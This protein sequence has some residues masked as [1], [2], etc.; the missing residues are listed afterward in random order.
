MDSIRIATCGNQ[1]SVWALPD[2]SKIYE[3]PSSREKVT[4]ATWNNDGTCLATCG[5]AKPDVISLTFVKNNAFSTSEISGPF[6]ESSSIKAVQFPHTS[7]KCLCLAVSDQ[8]VLYDL[9]KKKSRLAIQNTPNVTCISMSPNDKYI[10]AGNE[11]GSLF[12]LNTMMAKPAFQH[13]LR[14]MSEDSES[15]LTSTKF[16]N[17]KQSMVGACADNGLL[18]FWDINTAKELQKFSE[19]KAPATGMAFSPVNEALV[20]TAG[21][22]KRCVC[23]DTGTRK[24][25]STIWTDI[26]LTSVEF[27]PDGTNLALGTS[28]GLVYLY[29]LR[30]FN[31]PTAVFKAQDS[32]V[33]SVLF[34][35][36]G[37]RANISA[38]LAS[39]SKNSSTLS[40][41]S[42]S[43]PPIRNRLN[44]KE[45]LRPDDLN[46]TSFG[47]QVFSPLRDANL[48]GLG[49]FSSSPNILATTPNQLHI[50]TSS[51]LSSESVLSP[52]RDTSLNM[53]SPG[54]SFNAFKKFSTPTVLTSIT[55]ETASNERSV[56][57]E[58]SLSST[59][60]NQKPQTPV[61]IDIETPT[62]AKSL[63][64][65][66]VISASTPFY[67]P[68]E[69]RI[70]RNTD[71]KTLPEE[72]TSEVSTNVSTDEVRN[73]LTAF[74]QALESASKSLKSETVPKPKKLSSSSEFDQFRQEFVQAAVEEAMDEFCA[75]MRKQMWHWHYDMIKAFQQQSRE[76]KV[77][78]KENNDNEALVEE[79]RRLRAENEQLKSTPFLAHFEKDSD[80]RKE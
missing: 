78:M 62:P 25:I 44:T 72:E 54:S 22:D 24:P 55:E 15:A 77:L 74:P 73:I 1:V 14:I 17:V 19:H 64:D 16:N 45:N 9:T 27:A 37:D 30:S 10:A 38:L 47:S 56:D 70:E 41:Q 2:L 12:I 26:P 79:V 13:P 31:S 50:S 3:I 61:K 58:A 60:P 21:L 66:V 6:G 23:Y 4:S 32:S 48:S 40:T 8:I 65:S 71:E 36:G 46:N 43:A 18:A 33:T 20:L 28:Q 69:A 34:Q 53:A 76:I 29:D 68:R 42:Q 67:I 49:R 59:T 51:R 39:L 52:L 11:N 80:D 35:P 57:L 7:Q 75:D 63:L 5:S